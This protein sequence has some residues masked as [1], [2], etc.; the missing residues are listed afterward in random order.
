LARGIAIIL[1][2]RLNYADPKQLIAEL[3]EGTINIGG[4]AKEATVNISKPPTPEN[5]NPDNTII[6]LK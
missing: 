6:E 5:I 4:P 1:A 3:K 2:P